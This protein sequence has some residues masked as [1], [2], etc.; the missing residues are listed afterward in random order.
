[1]LNGDQMPQKEFLMEIITTSS[2]EST[3]IDLT[4]EL[5]TPQVHPLSLTWKLG[6]WYSPDILRG[7]KTTDLPKNLEWLIMNVYEILW[8]IL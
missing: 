4:T 1:M 5:T 6:M 7:L 3:M 8:K 2:P